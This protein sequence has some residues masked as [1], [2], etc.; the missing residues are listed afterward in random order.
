MILGGT[1]QAGII[2]FA[3]MFHQGRNEMVGRETSHIPVLR[4]DYDMEA[5]V[6]HS[7]FA[8]LPQTAERCAGSNHTRT[9]NLSHFFSAKAVSPP[10]SQVRNELYGGHTFPS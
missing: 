1:E 8:F 2:L 7:E 5:L 10:R 3:Q 6:G 9:Q 4:G